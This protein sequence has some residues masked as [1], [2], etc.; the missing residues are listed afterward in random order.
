MS[1]ANTILKVILD[2]T[3]IFWVNGKYAVKEIKTPLEKKNK[4]QILGN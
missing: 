2:P 4:W 1:I 3:E